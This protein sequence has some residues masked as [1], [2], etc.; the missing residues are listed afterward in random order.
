VIQFSPHLIPVNR[1]I[2]TTLYLAPHKHFTTTAE[3]NALA[4]QISPATAPLTEKSRS[5]ASSKAKPCRYEK[6]PWHNMIEIAWRLDQRT[7]RLIVMS[8]LDNIVKGA[9]G[10]RY[11]ASIFSAALTKQPDLI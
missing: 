11:K 7:G 9:S 10:Q 4:E 2:L 3:M 5:C 1:G 8:A 6:C